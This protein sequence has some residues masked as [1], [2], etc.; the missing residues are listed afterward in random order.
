MATRD[1]YEILGVPRNATQEEIKRAYRRLARQYHPDVNP[2][3]KEAEQ[4]FKEIQEAYEVLSDPEKRAQYDR[5]GPAAFDREAWARAAESGAYRWSAGPR[6]FTFEFGDFDL[7]DLF[8]SFGFGGAPFRTATRRRAA[9]GADVET[10]VTVPFLTAVKGGTV[11]LQVRRRRTCAS[12]GARGAAPDASWIT[13]RLCGGSGRV[14]TRGLFGGWETCPE[15]GGEGRRPARLCTR[16]GGEGVV[17]DTDTIDVKVPPGVEEGTRIRLKG[18]GEAVP[19]GEPGDLYVTIHVAPH[20]YFR[21]EGQD[22]VLRLPLSLTEAAL[23]T[24]V[25]VPTVDGTVTLHVPPGTSSHQRLRLRGK[26][27]PDP[28]TNV[29]GDQLVEV[30]IVVPKD[31]TSRAREL[32][33]QLQRELRFDPR[34]GVPW[35]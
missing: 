2:G 1:Y 13:C 14:R 5:F 25:E 11:S 24:K 7:G 20:P 23:G 10:E 3:N 22:I 27:V 29:R 21:R 15:C 12:C 4:K 9:R 28:K 17:L 16:C 19:G 6:E 31:L 34:A 32:L 30:E 26:G 8:E 35:R 18:Q 33:E